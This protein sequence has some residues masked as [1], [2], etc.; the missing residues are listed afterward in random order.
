MSKLFTIDSAKCSR[1]GVCVAAC[2]VSIIEFTDESQP[3][4]PVKGAEEACIDCGHCVVVCPEGVLSHRAMA[5]ED[6]QP[7]REELLP[8]AE[9]VEHMIRTRRSIRKYKD[10]AVEREVI[11]KLIDVARFAPT[12]HNSQPIEW[13]VVYDTAEVQKLTGLVIDWMRHLVREKSPIARMFG[14]ALIVR[15]WDM[16]IDIVCRKAPHLIIAHAAEV[17]KPAQSACTIAMTTLDLAAPSLGVGTCWA[18]FFHFAAGQWP[19]LQ[20]ALALP[21]GHVCM[22][23]MMVGHPKFKY[24]RLPTRKP[25][26]V[27]WR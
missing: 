22:A 23:A 16:G 20:E 26:Q 6:C 18:G 3:P 13:L 19:P 24:R 21:D 15:A 9:Q 8:N 12:G 5:P 17:N 2:P 14:M 10:E 11:E 1:D 7:V 27:E 25:A 4:T